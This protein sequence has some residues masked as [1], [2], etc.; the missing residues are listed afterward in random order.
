MPADVG[1]DSQPAADLGSGRVV[2]G[3]TERLLH[4]GPERLAVEL[5]RARS[6][7]RGPQLAP[8]VV[9]WL[10]PERSPQKRD[11]II[12][13]VPADREVGGAAKP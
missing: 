12:D 7:D 5:Q 10:E 6:G 13:L 2:R 8:R 11:R 4:R 3:E 9:V 1:L